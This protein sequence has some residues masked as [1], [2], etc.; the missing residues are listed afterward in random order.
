MPGLAAWDEVARAWTGEHAGPTDD[1][2]FDAVLGA[3]DDAE[4]TNGDPEQ[5]ITEEELAQAEAT[6]G[7]K[8]MELVIAAMRP[9]PSRMRAWAFGV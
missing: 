7:T 6:R 5:V 3:R 4:L 2:L 8:M 1:A 9:C